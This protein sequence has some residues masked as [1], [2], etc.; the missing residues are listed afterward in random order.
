MCL[1]VLESIMYHAGSWLGSCDTFRPRSLST[2]IVWAMVRSWL[3]LDLASLPKAESR[4]LEILLLPSALTLLSD[5]VSVPWDTDMAS[6]ALGQNRISQEAWVQTLHRGKT[7]DIW[8]LI[9]WRGD[10]EGE[11]SR[12]R[13]KAKT[14]KRAEIES[15]CERI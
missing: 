9:W 7:S 3:L 11:T 4:P 6:W 1:E 8:E 15:V 14:P 2:F 12:Q 5:I 10:P 13:Q